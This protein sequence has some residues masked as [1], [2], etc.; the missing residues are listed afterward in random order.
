[1]EFIK[2][3]RIRRYYAPL[4]ISAT[5]KVETP[6][7]GIGQVYAPNS[8]SFNPDREITPLVISPNIEASAVDGSWTQQKVANLIGEKKWFVNGADISTLSSWQ[9]KYAIDNFNGAITI[10]KNT[11]TYEKIEL[12]FE[13]VLPD[14]RQGVTI[15]VKTNPVVLSTLDMSKD[16]FAISFSTEENFM[17]NPFL[18]KL[19]MYDYKQA[20]GIPAGNRS[21]ALDENAYE[22]TI[23]MMVTKGGVAVNTGYALSLKRVTNNM[24]L[25]NISQSGDFFHLALASNKIALDMRMLETGSYVIIV[26][27]DETNKEVARKQFSVSRQSP[28]YDIDIFS[29]ARISQ[30][31]RLHRNKVTVQYGKSIVEHPAPILR[32]L[33]LTETATEGLKEWNEGDKTVI[34]ILRAGVGFTYI[35]D[36]MDLQVGS[37]MKGIFERVTDENGEVFTDENG[38]IFITN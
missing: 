14:E 23:E 13:G 33:W 8:N 9:G 15:P 37:E 1:M 6:D 11:E 24:T 27:D 18:D 28:S 35:N 31:D 26:T 5:L 3:E 7:S 19:L 36:S 30:G 21:D 10:F 34:D 22:R 16:T 32:F 20:N 29:T 12:H 2:Q 17:Y 4:I 25:E 38:E